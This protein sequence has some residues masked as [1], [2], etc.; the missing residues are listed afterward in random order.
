MAIRHRIPATVPTT[1]QLGTAT[2]ALAW[3]ANWTLASGLEA[4]L[5]GG[6]AWLQVAARMM[7][8]DGLMVAGWIYSM[9]SSLEMAMLVVA[10]AMVLEKDIELPEDVMTIEM[11]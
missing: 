1:W 2:L 8:V 9:G 10:V 4:R 6:R 3:A 7:G 11:V 5:L